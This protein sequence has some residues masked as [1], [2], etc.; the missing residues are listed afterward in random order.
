[1]F[2]FC[3][4][5]FSEITFDMIIIEQ[6][7]CTKLILAFK[8]NLTGAGSFSLHHHVQTETGTHPASC[9]VGTGSSFPR[10]KVARALS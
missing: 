9:A 8:C 3:T 4:V 1:M 2:P 7:I 5:L 6:N 10:G